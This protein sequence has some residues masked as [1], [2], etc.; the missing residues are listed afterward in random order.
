MKG[1]SGLAPAIGL[2]GVVYAGSDDGAHYKVHA[3]TELRANNGAYDRAPW[4]QSRGDP[5]NTGR[6]RSRP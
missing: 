1:S 5:A 4:P 2:D 6:A 3:F